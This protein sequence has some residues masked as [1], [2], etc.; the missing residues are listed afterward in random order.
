VSGVPLLADWNS[1]GVRT[2]GVFSDGVWLVTN[3][4]AARTALTSM[5]LASTLDSG[6]RGPWA[7]L[8]RFGSAGDIPVTGD[9]DG[10]G[11]LD[12]GVFNLGAWSWLTAEGER[13]SFRFGSVGSTPVVADFDGD[14]VDDMG[15]VKD[16]R[17]SLRM[18]T[19]VVEF[20]YGRESDIPVVGDWDADGVSS[21]GVFRDSDTWILSSGASAKASTV[22]VV[23][24][25]PTGAQPLVGSQTSFACPTVVSDYNRVARVTPAAVLPSQPSASR[26]GAAAT[27][28]A[29][30]DGTSFVFTSDTTDLLADRVDMP[31]Y[32]PLSVSR[33]TEKAVRRPAN[34][35]LA[36]ATL[37]ASSDFKNVNGIS[38]D[39][40]KDY[41]TWHIRSLACQHVSVTPGGWGGTWQSALWATTLAQAA[42]MLWPDLSPATRS[43]VQSMLVLEA[44]AATARGPRYFRDRDGSE[45]TPGNSH[46]DDVSWDLLAPTMAAA[47]LRDHPRSGIWLDAATSLAIA[48]FSRPGDLLGDIVVNG[49][50]VAAE[51]GGTNANE[52]GSITNHG[53][54]NPDYAQ[55]VQHLWW[56]VTLL[57]TAGVPVPES[58][59]LNADIVYR[60]LSTISFDP[61]QYAAP[62]GVV[63]SPDGSIYYPMGADWGVNRPATFA[64]VDAFAYLYAPADIGAA[65]FLDIHANAVREQQDRFSTGQ[66]YYPSGVEDSYAYG[67][68]EYALSQM[69]LAW[70]AQS[71]KKGAPPMVIN[72]APMPGIS[73]SPGRS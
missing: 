54:V 45:L 30:R 4:A 52:D 62:G 2:P 41:A 72:N 15:V 69:A 12:I 61:P 24:P 67:K 43:Y 53:M 47:M 40:V 3:S 26:P 35:A 37:V 39:Q 42:W 57:R 34:A 60:S 23:A 14:G 68:D 7:E 65:G 73:L 63:Y 11:L 5:A 9:I 20:S 1:D 8:T 44:D 49:T 22:T 48:S 58:F 38:R 31:F 36:A 21:P 32:D 50:D 6:S 46:S 33:F 71:W 25:L 66:F 55:N 18:G 29:L 51:L 64:G 28:Q 70:W 56:A 27:L 17:W 13:S 19:E 10:D 16:A 59:F